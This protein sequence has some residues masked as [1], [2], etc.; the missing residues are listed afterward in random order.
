MDFDLA[1]K[2]LRE[3]GNA[4]YKRKEYQQAIKEYRQGFAYT[5][6]SDPV[7]KTN[8]ALC[9]IELRD[10]STAVEECL[11]ALKLNPKNVKAYYLLGDCYLNLLQFDKAEQTFK[12]AEVLAKELQNT[13][14]IIM[15]RIYRGIDQSR[16]RKFEQEEQQKQQVISEVSK[17][18]N[19]IMEDYKNIKRLSNN[20]LE[21]HELR[22]YQLNSF[23]ETTLYTKREKEVPDF[24]CCKITYTILR[25]PVITPS[26]ITYEREAIEKHIKTN[27]P[28]CPVTRQKCTIEQLYPNIIVKEMVEDWIRKHPYTV[29][30]DH[31]FTID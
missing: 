28:F 25:D 6:D 16:A 15:N 27:G 1:A 21:D 2:K 12:K 26:G 20:Q 18:V 23:F 13:S 3:K 9:C 30:E 19:N 4:H 14:K 5:N 10:Y 7:F 17:Y 31:Y 24:L 11:T 22:K 8:I 29:T